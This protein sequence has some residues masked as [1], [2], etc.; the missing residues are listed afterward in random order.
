MRFELGIEVVQH[1]A[2][3]DFDGPLGHIQVQNPAQVFAVVDHQARAH[4]LTA[5][6]G[7]TAA[8]HDGDM[9]I[10][11]NIE[12]QFNV[13]CRFGNKSANRDDLVNRRIGGVAATVCGA[14]EHFALCFLGQTLG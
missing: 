5:L 13:L 2:G 14:E 6:A 4:G 9:Q 10:A 8:R 11:A 7:A 3:L 1:D 12:R